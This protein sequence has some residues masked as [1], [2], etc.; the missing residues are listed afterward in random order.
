MNRNTEMQFSLTP[1]ANI[2]RSLFDRSTQNK[3]SF[4]AGELIPIFVDEYLPGDTFTLDTALVIRTSSA[5]IKPVMDNMYADIYYFSVPNRLVWEHWREFMGENTTGP[6]TQTT[7]YT[8]PQ[9][10]APSG[11]WDIGTIADYMGIPTKVPNIT[12]SDMFFRAYSLI[13]NEYFRDQNLQNPT[14][15]PMTDATIQGSNGNT[16][17]TDACK[18]GKPLPVNKYHDYFTS[19]LPEPQRCTG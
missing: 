5:M 15:V 11:G 10:T 2:Q 12:I 4:N 17:E 14:N 7:E 19:A 6:W 9:V 16:I 1:N 8:I 13:W 3:L 18:G